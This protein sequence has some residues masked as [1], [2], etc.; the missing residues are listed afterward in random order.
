MDVSTQ[1]VDHRE[2]TKQRAATNPV[3]NYGYAKRKP[4]YSRRRYGY[5]RAP[6]RNYKSRTNYSS[7][8][9]K[10]NLSKQLSVPIPECSMH[11]IK[12]LFDPA[13]TPAGVC[14]PTGEFPIP[15]QK[16]KS[17]FRGVLQLGTTGYG[18]VT[19]A[20][21]PWN[22]I[23]TFSVT[24]SASVGGASTALNAFTNLGTGS[25]SQLPYADADR[26][27]ATVQA[28]VVAVDLRVRYAGTESGRSG[29][30]V[31]CEEQDLQSLNAK[32]YNSIKDIPNAY[33]TRPSG[34]GSWDACVSYSG[35]VAPGN[36]E[37]SDASY[38]LVGT[39]GSTST[40]FVIVM[41]GQ[42]SDNIEFES[43][44]HIEYIGTKV[45]GKTKSHADPQ[46]YGKVLESTKTISATEPL[47]PEGFTKGFGDFVRAVA[48]AAPKIIQVGMGVAS[49]LATGNPIPAIAGVSGALLGN[50]PRMYVRPAMQGQQVPRI[51]M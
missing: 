51:T 9:R 5:Y 13:S 12:A 44:I 35:P 8:A 6:A 30:Y 29:L 18:Y 40:P 45:Q 31:A 15:S 41:Q 38:P 49:S 28:R 43:T 22:D 33:T 17:T 10:S 3:S 11:Y 34:D 2:Q 7:Y 37:Y 24:T 20:P 21:S 42:A 16:I 14:I 4:Q 23:T 27:A 46:T 26:S 32:S 1:V 36:Y 19:M 39:G 47:R 48:D 50:G 25:Y